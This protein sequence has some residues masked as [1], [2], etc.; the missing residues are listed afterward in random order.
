MKRIALVLTVL[1][2]F[3]THAQEKPADTAQ[4]LPVEVRAVRAGATA[5]FAKTNLS[6][7][8]IRKQNLGQ[9]LPFLLNNTPSVV[10][11]SD[12]GNGVGY[13][14]M[15]IRGTDAT[16][17]NVTLNGIPYNDAES[18]GTFFVDL[19]D[20]ASSVNSIQV[21]RG[22]GTSTNGAGAFG[23]TLNLS[24]NEV[25][26]DA[27]AEINNSYGSFSTLKNTVRAG[28]GLLHDHFTTDIRIS[29]LSSAGYI[30]RASSD[31]KALYLSSAWVSEKTSL[32]FNYF[33]GKEKTYQAWYGVP[34]ADLEK[35][36]T[37]NYAGTEKP[38]DPYRDETD[39]YN[40]DHYQLF[41]N[42]KLAP[43]LDFNTGIFLTRGLGYYEQY[44]G[45][46]DYADYGMPYPVVGP[47]TVFNTDL[48]RR[49]W[50]DNYFYG[51]IFSLQH[52]KGGTA[53][54]LGGAWTRYDGDH[55]GIITWAEK[56]A[57]LNHPWYNTDAVKRDV[58]VYGKWQEEV[59]T[60][61]QA[62]LDLQYRS[63]RYNLDGFRYNPS[64]AVNNHYHFFNPKAGVSYS[65]RNWMAYASYSR[66]TKE[67][68][69]D[70]FEAGLTQQP[71]PEKLGDLEIGLE[72]K[73]SRWNWSANLY[74]MK[75]KDQLVLTGK[76]NDVGAYTRTNIP[77]SYRAGIELQGGIIF[78]DWLRI[79]GN[80]TFSRNKIKAFT[81]YLDDYDA[82]GQK[83]NFFG[84]TSIAFSP[85]VVGAG[86]I[87]ITP[88]KS[89]G[90]DLLSKYVSRQYLDNTSNRQRSLH[91]YYVQDV[92][93][94]FSYGRGFL[95]N[96][97]LIVQ[98][99]NVL[100]KMYEPNGYTFSYFYNNRLATE[101]FYF[102]MA[103]INYMV[104]LN[105]RF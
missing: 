38:G 43:S 81:E 37:V 65:F 39:N 56:G 24:T 11:N 6:R 55:Y 90:I 32:R 92:R 41:F 84:E 82:G 96:A 4:L 49:L 34:E 62:F 77:E 30:D 93:A 13:T 72:R 88:L 59:V 26:R 74:Y 47:D 16:R 35:N 19:P 95:K 45:G 44:K 18:G 85:N 73:A 91:P 58:T 71:R 87:T 17:I 79:A 10:V 70:D 25:V 21:Q 15:R 31:L 105:L 94:R 3:L 103:G 50:L 60:G 48:T 86:T 36:R 42:Q 57:P 2:P 33:T 75:Y 53:L 29:R 80:L 69:R 9:D 28:T 104:G 12:A 20:F 52:A 7:E 102:P 83:E 54:T 66:A 46:E 64:L 27:Y 63:V 14:G 97:D 23:A 101:N 40:Q 76:I 8:D 98:V 22:V 99:N 78:T 89:L 1:S 67:P 51:N 100:N 5:P 68:N 61:L